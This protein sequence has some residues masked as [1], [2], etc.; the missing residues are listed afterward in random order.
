VN[1]VPALWTIIICVGIASG[2]MSGLCFVWLAKP[3]PVLHGVIYSSSILLVSLVLA[4][5]ANHLIDSSAEGHGSVSD[6]MY[7][8][9][10]VGPHILALLLTIEIWRRLS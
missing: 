2:V 10:A 7:V 5:I 4:A 8:L 1:L 9:G 3:K 6:M